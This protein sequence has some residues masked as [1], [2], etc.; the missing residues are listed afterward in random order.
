MILLGMYVFFNEK[1]HKLLKGNIKIN[2]VTLALLLETLV[3][4]IIIASL[5]SL[6]G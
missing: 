4:L 5:S 6:G 1:Q 2:Y 3:V